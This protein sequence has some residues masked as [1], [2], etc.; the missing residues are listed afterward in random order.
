MFWL[1]I[2]SVERLVKDGATLA[3]AASAAQLRVFQTF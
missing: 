3:V 2:E 1:K